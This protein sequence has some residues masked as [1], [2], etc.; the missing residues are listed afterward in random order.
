MLV[1]YNSR[2]SLCAD[3][4]TTPTNTAQEPEMPQP[5]GKS[6]ADLLGNRTLILGDVRS[7]K[8]RLTALLLREAMTLGFTKE[9][10]V[11]D[12]APKIAT[13]KGLRIGG[14]LFEVSKRPEGV[15][16]LAPGRVETPRLSAKGGEELLRLVEENRRRIY[17]LLRSYISKPSPI[18]FANDVSLYLQSGDLRTLLETVQAASTFVGNGYCGIAL[19]ADFSTGISRKERELMDQLAATM[20]VQIRLT[21]E[22]P[23]ES[24]IVPHAE[25]ATAERARRRPRGANVAKATLVKALFGG[26]KK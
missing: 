26:L 23:R 9:I 16:Y 19:A 5:T 12:M 7:G 15:R 18:L 11:I 10:T 24:V 20:D 6:F 8:T 22:T 2:F 17:P 4:Y 14:R 3:T 13:V 21:A 1:N 25:E